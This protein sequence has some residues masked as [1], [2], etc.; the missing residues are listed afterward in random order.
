MPK[1]AV[2]WRTSRDIRHHT[3]WTCSLRSCWTTLIVPVMGMMVVF[4]TQPSDLQSSFSQVFTW[5][6]LSAGTLTSTRSAAFYSLLWIVRSGLLQMMGQ[7]VI[8]DMSITDW[9]VLIP[10]LWDIQ[11]GMLADTP[12]DVFACLVVPVQ[13]LFWG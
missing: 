8:I 4:R 10:L 7:S 11:A 1:I 9:L 6:L 12:G 5:C 2:C 13:V 3:C